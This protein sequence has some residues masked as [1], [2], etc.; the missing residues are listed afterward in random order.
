VQAIDPNVSAGSIADLESLRYGSLVRPRF[1]AVLVGLFA[2]IAGVIAAVGL[3]AVL[4][5]AVVQRTHEIGVRMALGARRSAVM[6]AVL[7]S[8]VLL[9]AGGAA[10]G[11]AGAA[12]LTRS[13]STMLFGLSPLDAGTYAAVTVGLIAVA[14]LASA[15]PARRATSVDPVVALRSE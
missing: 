13:L 5:F 2:A 11:L 1:Y 10:L 7:R 8:G 3:Y 4:A 6:A 14:A 15:V 9:A 12:V